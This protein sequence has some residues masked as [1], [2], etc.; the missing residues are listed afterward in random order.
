MKIK[1]CGMKHNIPEVASLKPAYLG[2]IFWEGSPRYFEGLIPN[3]EAGIK[4]VGVF[5]NAS[6]DTI[7]TL[8]KEHSLQLVQLHGS[9]TPEFCSALREALHAKDNPPDRIAVIKV[10]S[11]RD[12]FDFEQIRQYEAVCEYFL[13]DTKGE[14]PGGNG[15]TFDWQLLEGYPSNKPFFLSGGIG[16]GEL[17]KIREFLNRP[18]AQ[19]CHAIDVNSGF[20]LAPGNKNTE[21][22]KLFINELQQGFNMH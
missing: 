11:I 9:E 22:L 4:K 17:P 6:L 16:P 12:S 7:C 21:S 10:F 8:V 13:F 14:L 2:F 1:V 15:Y 3:L 19:F 18:E 5:V 20:E